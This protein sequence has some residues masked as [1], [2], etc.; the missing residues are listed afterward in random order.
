MHEYLKKQNGGGGDPTFSRGGIHLLNPIET[1]RTCDFAGRESEPPTLPRP[2]LDPRMSAGQE[3]G[4]FIINIILVFHLNNE[5]CPFAPCKLIP[6]S[7]RLLS[8]VDKLGKQF[9]PRSGPT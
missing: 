9:E 1:Y 5:Y 6:C 7:L 4:F 8:S 2:R 3:Q